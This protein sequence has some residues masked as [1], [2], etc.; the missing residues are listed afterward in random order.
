MPAE[1]NQELIYEIKDEIGLITLN[2]PQARNAL[3]FEMYGRIADILEGAP[4]D[5][6]VKAFIITGAGDKAFAAGTDI[7]LFRDF[8]GAGQGIGYETHWRCQLPT[9]RKVSSAG[10][11]CNIRRLYGR[12]CRHCSVQRHANCFA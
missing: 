10:H 1:T 5:G 2:R 7:S 12:R 11:C 6:S 4:T 8:N 3:T 9:Y